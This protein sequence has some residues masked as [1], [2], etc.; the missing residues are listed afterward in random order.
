MKKTSLYNLLL[1]LVLLAAAVPA[2]VAAFAGKADDATTATGIETLLD[3]NG[4]PSDPR[5]RSDDM[6]SL[7]HLLNGDSLK[8]ENPKSRNSDNPAP[9]TDGQTDRRTDEPTDRQTDRPSDV[10]ELATVSDAAPPEESANFPAVASII[11]NGLRDVHLLR[12]PFDESRSAMAWTNYLASLDIDRMY[13]RQEDLDALEPHRLRLPEEM[14]AG[15]LTFAREAYGLFMDRVRERHASIDALLAEPF[16]FT[17]D[18]DYTWRRRDAPWPADAAEQ[19]DLW[20]RRI[21]NELLSR[22]LNQELDAEEAAR[23]ESESPKVRESESPKVRESEESESPKVEESEESET[24][25]TRNPETPESPD[26]GIPESRDPEIPETAPS[27]PETPAEFLRKRYEKLLSFYED[28]DSEYYLS[29][30]FT[31]VCMSYDPHTDYFS[32]VKQEDFDIDMQLSL[33]GIG[34]TLQSEDGTAKISEIIPGGP[35][36]RDTRD[37]RLVPGDRII[38]VAQEGDTEFTDILHWPLYKAVR[39]IRGPKGTR[40]RLLVQ[41]ADDPTHTKTRVVELVRDEVKLEEQAATSQLETFTDASGRERRVGVI[42]LPT[43]YAG[44]DPKSGATARAC[45][46][47]IARLLAELKG[48][49]IEGLILDLRGNG[50]GALKEAVGLTGLFIRTGPV[51]LVKETRR[52][53]PLKDYNPAVAFTGPMV[54]LVDRLSAS[55]SEIVA[56]ALQDYGRAIVIG[57]TR[58]HGKGTVQQV[59]PLA[60]GILGSI[61]VTNAGFFRITGDS[62]Q[63][64]GVESDIHLPSVFEYYSE[65]GEDK[66]PN[67][68]PWSRVRGEPFRRVATLGP[69]IEVLREKSAARLATD[70]RWKKHLERLETVRRINDAAA[71][72]L[73]REKRLARLR[74]ERAVFEDD[75]PTAA[76]GELAEDDDATAKPK[77]RAERAAARRAKDVVLD[78]ALRILADFVDYGVENASAPEPGAA[79]IAIPD[80]FKQFF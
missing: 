77:T 18:E 73:E 75:D 55:A 54:V 39:L 67:A 30:F 50:G 15:D 29:R 46:A 28:T 24:P 16:D 5:N 65:L 49:D 57:D 71:V 2:F 48:R 14:R 62:T 4:D 31:A 32:P 17:V 38:A 11:A 25:E 66:L 60:E 47:D 27:P 52:T 43:F 69:A 40:V 35:A 34:A 7:R 26:P 22:T 74:E 44:G 10:S 45:S 37:I 12:L 63:I 9:Q 6:E 21:K 70:E 76:N 3:E 68:I 33:Q 8:T 1:F 13:L 79:P 41:C 53:I 19:D 59:I 20:R 36:D 56:G 80:I 64:K 23:K 78:E 42:T 51:V 61:K 58:T 72:P